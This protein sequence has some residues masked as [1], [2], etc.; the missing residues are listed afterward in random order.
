MRYLCLVLALSS[1]LLAHG[2][3]A[4]EPRRTGG[5][6]PATSSSATAASQGVATF[7]VVNRSSVAVHAIHVSPA[8]DEAWGPDLLGNDVLEPGETGTIDL[9]AG[10]WDVRCE[11]EE[12][13]VLEYFDVRFGQDDYELVLSDR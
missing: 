13:Q 8:D 5:G 3:A 7:T 4:D 2:C 12:G 10:T 6:A 1:L 11:S 9:D